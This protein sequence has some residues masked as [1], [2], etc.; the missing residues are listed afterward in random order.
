MFPINFHKTIKLTLKN[1]PKNLRD[2]SLFT[3]MLSNGKG[4]V[5][6]SDENSSYHQ[7]KDTISRNSSRGLT[8][9]RIHFFAK[10]WLLKK[11]NHKMK[12]ISHLGFRFLRFLQICYPLSAHRDTLCKHISSSTL[13]A[14]RCRE[15]SWTN[16][17]HTHVE[18]ISRFSLGKLAPGGDPKTD[19]STASNHGE[20]HWTE[21]F[22]D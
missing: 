21:G 22:K 17:E 6:V 10:R 4:N 2:I 18:K 12:L 9:M 1:N 19:W 8:E 11:R 15:K 16:K 20:N 3:W 5:H 7:Q 14:W 13:E